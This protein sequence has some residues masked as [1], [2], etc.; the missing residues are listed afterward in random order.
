MM[1]EFK[2]EDRIDISKKVMKLLVDYYTKRRD[3]RRQSTSV[4]ADAKATLEKLKETG[5]DFRRF[6]A[7]IGSLK[8][9]ENPRQLAN[10]GYR[11]QGYSQPRI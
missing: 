5:F 2:V 3:S 6:E 11:K 7:V 10:L 8:P 1:I 9:K 4:R